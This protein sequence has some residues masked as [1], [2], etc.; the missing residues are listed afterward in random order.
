MDFGAVSKAVVKPTP[1]FLVVLVLCPAFPLIYLVNVNDHVRTGVS[2]GTALFFSV[3]HSV[4]D[5]FLLSHV[6]LLLVLMASVAF[7]N[8]S[9][10]WGI[11]M[12][13]YA[14]SIGISKMARRSK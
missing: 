12:T 6:L 13:V 1:W 8:S 14:L 3:F 7:K 4:L 5:K 11:G 10:V 9:R 2:V